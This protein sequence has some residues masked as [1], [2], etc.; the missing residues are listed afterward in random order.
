MRR[1]SWRSVPMMCRPPAAT[2]LSW[3]SSVIAL[4]SAR[5]RVHRLLV[6]LGRVEAALVERLGGETGRVAAEQDVGAAAGHV[7]GDGDRTGPTGLRDDPRF[8]LVELGVED[9]VLDAAALEHRGQHL[10]LLDGHGADEDRP[11]RLGHLDDLV[12]Q[13]VELGRLVAVDEVGEVL[14]DHLAMG[15]DRDDLELVDLVQLL[16]LG[17]RRAG[18]P[19]SL[20]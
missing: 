3:S 15:R 9:L 20:S 10:G 16:G 19:D 11:A 17:H 1:E 2:T 18:H 13:R 14:A 4:A 7:G 8:L 12:D 5:R 6:H